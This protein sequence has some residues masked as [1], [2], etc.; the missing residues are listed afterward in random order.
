MAYTFDAGP[1]AVLF[2]RE[3]DLNCFASLLFSVFGSSSFENFFRGKT[4]TPSMEF[5]NELES[6]MLDKGLKGQVEYTIV[7][8]VGQGPKN[9]DP[10]G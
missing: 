1:N 8:R 4:P 10:T 7:S 6:L 9:V 2:L 5:P 3:E